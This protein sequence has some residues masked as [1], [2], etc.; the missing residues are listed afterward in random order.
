MI[1]IIGT[2][3]FRI[4]CE[5]DIGFLCLEEEFL[6]EICLKREYFVFVKLDF[7]FNWIG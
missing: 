1:V 6:N 4:R 5:R 2:K 3:S 7:S